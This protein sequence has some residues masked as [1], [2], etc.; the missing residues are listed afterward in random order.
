MRPVLSSFKTH[1]YNT[2]KFLIPYIDKYAKN[3]YSLSNSYEF[4]NDLKSFR[5]N[6]DHFIVSLDITS[7]YTNVPL[8]ETIDILTTLMY[9][10]DQENFRNMTK[11]EFKSL[12]ELSIGDTYF[13]FNKEYYKQKDGLA[14]GSPLSATLANIF[15]CFHERKW[16]DNCPAD[17]KPIYYKRYVDD[18]FVIFRNQEHAHHFLDYMNTRHNNI[19]FTMELEQNNQIPFLDI[20]IKKTSNGIDTSV[21]RKPTYTGLGINFISSCY[22]N[23]KLNAFNTM[24][25]RAFR[26]TSSFEN[27]HNEIKFLERF[28][29][30]NGYMSNIFYQK[31]RTF[32]NSILCPHPKKY[33]PHKLAVYIKIPYFNDR[34][35]RYF[36]S[37]FKR[38]LEKYLPQIAPTIIFYNNLKLKNFLNHKEKLPAF[39]DSMVVYQ[40]SCP[41]CQL[42]YI[43]STKKALFSRY[44]DHKGS[45]SRTGRTLSSPLYSNIRDHCENSCECN[46]SIDDFSVIF[47]GS[48]ETEIRIAES[49]LIRSKRPT[50]NQDS[51]SYP[52][53][54]T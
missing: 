29:M 52:L 53:K 12:L 2:A 34:T 27:F 23:F 43:G 31:L 42:A 10:Q 47:K 16:L 7:L 45:S 28:F 9:D 1:S 6:E 13:M 21:Y 32:L 20:L 44:H 17:F 50:L 15:L 30:Q 39:Y 22:E 19:S 18:T 11:R 51:A 33:G 25:Y 24:F 54:L 48:T 3:E 35:N 37:N 8:K 14:M 36:K 4:F 26:L 5:I 40:F 49:L 41:N 38:V 46:F